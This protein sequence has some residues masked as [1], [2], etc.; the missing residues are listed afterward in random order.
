MKKLL[1]TLF[2]LAASTFA[3]ADEWQ[4]CTPDIKA[5]V[6][7]WKGLKMT[8]SDIANLL[9]TRAVEGDTIPMGCVITWSDNN[10][11]RL[12][13]TRSYSSIDHDW[14]GTARYNG[15]FARVK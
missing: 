15:K 4:P 14:H 5:D 2:I 10:T 7:V 8:D 3:Q 11:V 1:S 9:A 13:S 12:D 6:L